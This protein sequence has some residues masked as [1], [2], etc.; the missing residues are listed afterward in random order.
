MAS[1]F[2]G[3]HAYLTDVAT[4]HPLS[5]SLTKEYLWQAYTGQHNLPGGISAMPSMHNAQVAL[6]VAFA[7]SLDRR[8]GHAM[9]VYAVL[10]FVGSIH[11]GW[12]YAVDGIVGIAAALAVWWVCGALLSRKA[13]AT[14]SLTT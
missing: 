1:P 3:L 13:E 7:Y 8:F 10:I 2:A 6:F 9:L 14:A 11:L 4:I 5:S 12:H